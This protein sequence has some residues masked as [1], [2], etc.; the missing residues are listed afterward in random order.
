M[1]GFTSFWVT[2]VI[3]CL[4]YWPLLTCAPKSTDGAFNLRTVAVAILVAIPL[5]YVGTVRQQINGPL[6]DSL[7]TQNEFTATFVVTAYYAENPKPLLH[8]ESYLRLPEY[9]MPR[10]IWPRKPISLSIQFL[11]DANMGF[12]Q[13]YAFNPVA[14]AFIKFGWAGPSLIMACFAFFLTWL[15]DQSIRFPVLCLTC[16]TLLVDFQRG[17]FALMLYEGLFVYAATRGLLLLEMLRQVRA[18]RS[19]SRTCLV[20]SKGRLELQPNAPNKLPAG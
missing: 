10:S 14:E 3:S 15:H 12:G 7:I 17:E 11:N 6:T 8:G 2:V 5:L 16:Y 9:L 4:Y 1:L 20:P 18:R 19:F 13:G